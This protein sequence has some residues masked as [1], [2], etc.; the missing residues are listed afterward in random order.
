MPLT[1]DGDIIYS[2]PGEIKSLIDRSFLEA[3]RNE[4][5]WVFNLSLGDYAYDS[6]A[7]N[8]GT[9][10][11]DVAFGLACIKTNKK[12][13]YTYYRSLPWY[14]SDIFDGE[15]EEMLINER[16]VRRGYELEH[17]REELAIEET[18]IGCCDFCGKYFFED[19]LIDHTFDDG[20]AIRICH[21]C[22]IVKFHPEQNECASDYY[23]SGIKTLDDEFKRR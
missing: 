15:V 5:Y 10:G 9:G 18:E 21:K 16:L 22:D 2:I 14:D 12:E 1:D 17:I 4:L 11:W 23:K 7:S 20:C 19:Q 6:A 3:L 8:G 13:I